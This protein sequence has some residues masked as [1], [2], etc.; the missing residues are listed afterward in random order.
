MLDWEKENEIYELR[1]KLTR[2]LKINLCY[3]DFDRYVVIEN[4][5]GEEE[6]V[7]VKEIYYEAL[8]NTYT[9]VA[10]RI[11]EVFSDELGWDFV[12]SY[13]QAWVNGLINHHI[14]FK[15]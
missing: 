15:Y 9:D 11:I 14:Y 10:D 4:S 8:P 6:L 13:K 1:N 12:S 3:T 7:Q 5:N 2:E